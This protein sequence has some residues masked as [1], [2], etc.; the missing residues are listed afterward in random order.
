M[1]AFNATAYW[2]QRYHHGGTSGAGSY[3]RLAQFKAAFVND[4]IRREAIGSMIDF[5]C[6]DGN[7]MSLF[8][9]GTYLGVDVAPGAITRCR[10]R[11]AGDPSRQFCIA[12]ALPASATAD[13]AL[14]MDVIFHLTDDDSFRLYMARLFASAGRFVIIYASNIDH[15]PVD[16]HVRHRRFTDH[17][18]ATEPDWRLC[19]HRI[20]PYPFDP[21]QP[22]QTSFADF[23]VF[24]RVN[25]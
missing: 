5:G 25:G 8:E 11:A 2:T 10:V 6:G 22:D 23:F 7:Q 1:N 12:S 3:G 14:S 17:V 15:Q 18:A 9:V 21:A 4:L 13:L 19:A 16:I 20:N 24:R